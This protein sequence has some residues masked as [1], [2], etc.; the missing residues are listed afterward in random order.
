MGEIHQ[1]MPGYSMIYRGSTIL[2]GGA[3]CRDHPQYELLV[4]NFVAVY[5]ANY[6][7]LKCG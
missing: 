3:G 1:L 5:I 2:F 6:L 7:G 4:L